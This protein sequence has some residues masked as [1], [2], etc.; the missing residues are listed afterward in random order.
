M[1]VLF[2]QASPKDQYWVHV[3]SS[4]ISMTCLK[5]YKVTYGS[6]QMI[7]SCT[8][9]LLISQRDLSRPH[10]LQPRE[11]NVRSL[12][13]RR[14]KIQIIFDYQLHG[15]TLQTT[16]NAKYLGLN[17]SADLTWSRRINQ[18]AA[19]RNN[20]LKFIK[21]NIQTHNSKN[22]K[23]EY[24]TYGIPLLEYSSSVWDPWQKKYTKKLEKVQHRAVRYILMTMGPPAA[25]QQC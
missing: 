18:T 6:L 5:A 23:T 10:G 15:I 9:P 16:K 20:T 11:I 3:F 21:R 4:C 19:K 13:L 2:C 14:Y 22:K 7:L 25:S 24:K 17:I 1:L 12:E 8:L